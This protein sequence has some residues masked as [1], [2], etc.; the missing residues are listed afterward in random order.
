[1]LFG[2]PPLLG[3]L[4]KV[5]VMACGFT[6]LLWNRLATNTLSSSP[7][8]PE[9]GSWVQSRCELAILKDFPG[10]TPLSLPCHH[11][12]PVANDHCHQCFI[13]PCSRIL[14]KTSWWRKLGNKRSP[15]VHQQTNNKQQRNQTTTAYVPT[16]GNSRQWQTGMNASAMCTWKEG[17]DILWS[18]RISKTMLVN[19]IPCI[20]G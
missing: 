6:A 19:T 11:F 2:L 16:T 13:Y 3:W 7:P 8:P 17:Q 20:N 12:L 9:D 15:T 1:M 5:K 4:V 10:K 14:V 18:E